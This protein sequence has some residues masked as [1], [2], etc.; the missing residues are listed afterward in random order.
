M[1]RCVARF[2]LLLLMLSAGSAVAARPRQVLLLHSFNRGF[3]SFQAFAEE[4]R[5]QVARGFTE[6]VVFYEV[7]SQA[8]PSNEN[9]DDQPTLNY[10]TSMFAKHQLDLVV[11]VGGPAAAFATKHRQTLFPET[12]L[13]LAAVDERYVKNTT[14]TAND[15]VVAVRNDVQG[16]IEN[17]RHVL[18]LTRTI[19]LVIGN[20]P[21]EQFWRKQIDGELQQFRSQLQFV[22]LN[23]LSFQEMLKRC[24]SLPPNSA[25]FYV[26]L[27]VDSEGTSRAES[28][29][30]SRLHAEASA[31]IFGVHRSQLGYGIVGGPLM[32]MDDLGSMTAGVAIRMLNGE[33]PAK[34][35]TSPQLPGRPV[36]D[37]RELSRWNI[38]ADRLPAESIVLF[39]DPGVWERYK[40]YIA[41]GGG[42]VAVQS[43]LIVALLANRSKRRRAE[44]AVRES[45]DRLSA[46]LGTAV[47]GIVVTDETGSIESVNIGLE[48]MFGYGES[49]LAGQN[50]RRLMADVSFS[51]DETGVNMEAQGTR[52]D[53]SAFPV[54]VAVS[55]VESAGRRIYTGFVRDITERKRTEQLAREFGLQLIQAQDAE[56]ARIARELH[57]GIIQRLA[58]LQS[59]SP[60]RQVPRHPERG[61]T[62]HNGRNPS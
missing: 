18:P 41:I 55:E 20:S 61:S 42:I 11:T 43:L 33:V 59:T 15:A 22:W 8:A 36:Y 40:S 51:S 2:G 48:K 30:L 60:F 16:V 46:I 6:E 5:T 53:G 31:P 23:D 54:A 45:R 57:D 35:K 38:G 49:E 56:C 19:F 39:R 34:I 52:K 47:E 28:V 10:L 58:R 21:H 37:W 4:F 24:A 29:S 50:V 62:P 14:L 13:L 27:S 26:L 12:P 44:A 1:Y 25:I 7:A 32:S 17:I 9:P 3:T